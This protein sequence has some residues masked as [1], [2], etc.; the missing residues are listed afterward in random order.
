MWM[1]QRPFNAVRAGTQIQ[2]MRMICRGARP[3]TS[4]DLFPSVLRELLVLAWHADAEER[5]SMKELCDSLRSEE[6][7]SAMG[8][9][10]DQLEGQQNEAG[11]VN[12]TLVGEVQARAS[13]QGLA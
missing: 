5:P 4:E 11:L 7:C 9:Q 8:A 1:G 13:R 2:F 6:F 12:G 10:Q 3:P